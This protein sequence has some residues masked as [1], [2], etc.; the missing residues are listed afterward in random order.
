MKFTDSIL[1]LLFLGLIV[2]FAFVVVAI[3]GTTEFAQQFELITLG[4]Y[5]EKIPVF[6]LFTSGLI[7]N[8]ITIYKLWKKPASKSNNYFLMFYAFLLQIASFILIIWLQDVTDVMLTSYN[9]IPFPNDVDEITLKVRM[10]LLDSVFWMFSVF[11]SIGV[12]SFVGV[13]FHL[14]GLSRD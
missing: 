13:L 11:G 1:N 3:M 14:K 4:A 12:I 8:Y 10:S 7:G 6:V 5:S 9:E 2:G